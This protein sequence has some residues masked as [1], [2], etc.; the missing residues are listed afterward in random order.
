[1]SDLTINSKSIVSAT[2]NYELLVPTPELPPIAPP[3]IDYADYE[4]NKK[5]EQAKEDLSTLAGSFL[6]ADFL[7]TS[8][9]KKANENGEQYFLRISR[10][11]DDKN[12]LKENSPQPFFSPKEKLTMGYIRRQLGVRENVITENNSSRFVANR[13]PETFNDSATLDAGK[14]LDIP[15]SELGQDT[16]FLRPWYCTKSE[17]E[18]LKTAVGKLEE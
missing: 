2:N 6:S 12:R 5:L 16:H 10:P 11:E 4:K 7:K 17:C 15:V 18:E 13:P 14:Y 3:I 1:M 8:V 9:I